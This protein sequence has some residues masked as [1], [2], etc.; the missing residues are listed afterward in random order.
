M[1]GAGTWTLREADKKY[2]GSFEVWCR[3]RKEKISWRDR[4]KNED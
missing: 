2:L 3:T 1:Y 4:V